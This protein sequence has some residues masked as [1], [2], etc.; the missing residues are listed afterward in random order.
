MSLQMIKVILSI[1]AVEMIKAKINQDREAD[2]L[3]K[4]WYN[5]QK[6]LNRDQLIKRHDEIKTLSKKSGLL[7]RGDLQL[8]EDLPSGIEGEV[9]Q[10]RVCPPIKGLKPSNSNEYDEKQ[11]IQSDSRGNIKTYKQTVFEKLNKP[12]QT[13]IPDDPFKHC[14]FRGLIHSD[15][16]SVLHKSANIFSKQSR[17][18][19][20]VSTDFPTPHYFSQTT[21]HS[22]PSINQ[23]SNPEPP[24]DS[25][26]ASH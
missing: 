12:K 2:H 16:D 15:Y 1:G 26:Y 6:M 20:H 25:R 19:S 24:L 8:F 11:I 23:L 3:L 21:R 10:N 5:D 13:Y 4:S 18:F 22:Q 9:L 14:E 17:R 7:D